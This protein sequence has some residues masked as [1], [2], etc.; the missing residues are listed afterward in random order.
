MSRKPDVLLLDGRNLV[1]RNGYTRSSLSSRGRPSGA[2]YG[3]LAAI[4]RLNRLFPDA[5]IVVCWDGDDGRESWRH[6][7]CP[8]YKSNRARKDVKTL[9]AAQKEQQR[10]ADA[11]RTQIPKIE[12][13]FALLGL[14]QFKVD[15]LEA[16]D[17]IGVLATSMSETHRKVMIY[18]TDRDF[19][20]LIRKNIVVVRDID[21]A[22][23]GLEITAKEIKKEYGVKPKNWLKYRAFVGDAGDKID[24]P[25]AGVGPA[26]ALKILASGV[27]A[28]QSTPHSDF[29]SS[30]KKI[31]LAY[32]L[33]K[34]VRRVSSKYLSYKAKKQLKA[35]I[36]S[37][38]FFRSKK[39]KKGYKKF[40]A[41]LADYE[42]E[43]ILK[44]KNNLW[45]IR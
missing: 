31:R 34:I 27:D 12:K 26:K 18:S 35:A 38:T 19:Y 10:V 33:S 14:A 6:K 32:K 17:L 3:C 42:L 37:E 9:S 4:L 43:D 15:K 36:D 41:F 44:V 8:E 21:K 22:K 20:Q 28:S 16:D 29:V 1:Y 40:V 7:L 24:K 25:I 30:W 5:A 45:S 11:I 2:I 39:T 23:Q 13:V